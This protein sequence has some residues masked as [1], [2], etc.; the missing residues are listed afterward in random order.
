MLL[1]N[2]DGRRANVENRKMITSHTD[3]ARLA[4]ERIVLGRM[5]DLAGAIR[6]HE[7]Q[8]ARGR[9]GLRPHD[10]TLYRRLRQAGAS[11]ISR[12]GH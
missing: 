11:R 9:T 7:G 4:S 2:K 10:Q 5:T 12:P 8:T 1:I 3:L 6:E